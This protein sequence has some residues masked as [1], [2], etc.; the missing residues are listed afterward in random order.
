MTVAR[1]RR[2]AAISALAALTLGVGL[3]GAGRLTYHE[4]I[5]AQAAR[6]MVATGDWLTPT[7]GGRPWLEKPPLA[8]WLAAA[9]ASVFGGVSETAARAPAALA[10]ALLSL[11]V[12]GFAARRFG[13]AA[14]LLAGLIQLTTVWTVVRGRLAEADI[15]L[16]A[17]VVGSDVAFDRL[18]GGGDSDPAPRAGARWAFFALLGLTCLAK[19]VGFGAVMVLAT[20]AAVVVWDRDV[21]AL[22]RLR[23]PGGWALAA[24]VGLTWPVLVAVRRPAVLSLW[25][26]HV[27]DRLAAEPRQFV[28]QTFWTFTFTLLGGLLPWMP[29]AA[30]GAVLSLR[31]TLSP[32]GRFGGDRLLWAWTL[33]PL[34]LLALATVKNAHYAIHALA[35]CSVWAACGL[36]RLGERLQARR[37]WSAAGVRRLAWATF[38][39]L[40]LAYAGS[41]A[42]LGP[43]FDRRGVEW[44]FYESARRLLRPGEPVALLYR[45]PDWDRLPYQ[46]PFGRFPH[47]WAVRLYY[48]NLDRAAPCVFDASELPVATSPSTSSRSPTFA[49]IGR[50]ADLPDLAALGRVDA[51]ASGPTVRADRTYRL[52]RVTPSPSPVASARASSTVR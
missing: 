44:G 39:G 26:L 40:G 27:S 8:M 7:I 20:V 25:F 13:P 6:E 41:F 22:R 46:T 35:P 31:R 38:G 9:S 18:R 15:L 3:G 32:G 37:G 17:L 42:L 16:A 34:G 36:M 51:L 30:A 21:E 43:Q 48:L 24:A 23:S 11:A 2:V 45:V 5:I 33:G 50:D 12:A 47:D 52:F 10:A 49:V 1:A 29:L 28:G 4:A 19:G 14:G